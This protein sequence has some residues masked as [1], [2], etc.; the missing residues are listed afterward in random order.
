MVDTAVEGRRKI[1]GIRDARS[2]LDPL[3]QGTP[4]MSSDH[5]VGYTNTEYNGEQM[6]S[7]LRVLSQIHAHCTDMS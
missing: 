2:P 7:C 6:D 1:L 4:K 5:D 3:Q